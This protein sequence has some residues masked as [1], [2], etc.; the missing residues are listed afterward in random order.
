LEYF[1]SFFVLQLVPAQQLSS[2]EAVLL[3]VPEQDAIRMVIIPAHNSLNGFIA[4][5]VLDKWLLC[6]HI[7]LRHEV[8]N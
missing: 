3:A 1:I 4:N 8:A 7:S 2:V 5:Y 6:L